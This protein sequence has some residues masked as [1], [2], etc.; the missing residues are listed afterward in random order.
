[1]TCECYQIGGPWISFDPDCPAHGLE[2]QREAEE[3][4]EAAAAMN[5]K[6]AALEAE[7]A[8]LKG[9]LMDAQL[10]ASADRFHAKEAL[11]TLR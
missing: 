3:R 8:R 2:A 7:V 1:M 4:D 9:L 6:V 10:R 11:K 5:C